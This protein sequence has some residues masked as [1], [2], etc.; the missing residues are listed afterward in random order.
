MV[1]RCPVFGICGGCQLQDVAY[2]DQLRWKFDVVQEALRKCGR[3]RI[4][5]ILPAVGMDNPWN[6]RTRITLHCDKK[7]RIGFY[8]KNSHEAVEF[9][10]CPIAAPEINARLADEKARIAGKPGHYEIRIDDGD[11]FTQINPVQNAV[12]QQ[13]LVGGLAGRP[14][15]AVIELFCGNGNFSFPVA[16]HVGKLY[17]CDSHRGS[18]E[19]AVA[20]AKRDGVKNIQFTTARS[21]NFMQDLL[22]QGIRATGLILDPPR[23]GAID[24]IHSVLEMLPLWIGYI[25]CNLHTLARD[26]KSL[27]QGGYQFESCQPVDMF[28]QTEHV[29]TI[30]W[31]SR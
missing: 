31:L 1:P 21:Q 14:A 25:S 28:P 4:P 24:V 3:I 15:N 26:L 29:E 7:G 2:A 27:C 16:P 9:D 19:A 13:L 30:S 22:S 5:K 12:L 20:R 11:G 18:I 8:K 6:Y 23:M 17:A 10:E